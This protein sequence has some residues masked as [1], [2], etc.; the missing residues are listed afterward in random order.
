[1]F[2]H[3]FGDEVLDGCGGAKYGRFHRLGDQDVLKISKAVISR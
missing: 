1:M 3:L 2:C